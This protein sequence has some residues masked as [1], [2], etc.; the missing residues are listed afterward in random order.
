MIGPPSSIANGT[1]VAGSLR[2]TTA[3][4]PGRP[5]AA[6]VAKPATHFM[7]TRSASALSPRRWAGMAWTNDAAARGWIAIFGGSSEAP[8]R[9]SAV[10]V[11]SARRSRSSM[12]G[13]AAVTSEAPYQRS[14]GRSGV[15]IGPEF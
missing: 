6:F 12:P 11:T 4:I 14:G 9:A 10:I 15:G 5:S 1:P 8:G 2:T 13:I 3:W 7:P